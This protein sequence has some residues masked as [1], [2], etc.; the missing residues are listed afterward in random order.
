MLIFSLYTFLIILLI[1]GIGVDLMRF[2]RDRS[3]LQYTLDRAVLAA[4]DLDQPMQP[5][6]VVQDYFAKSGLGAY[7]AD[8]SV[9]QGTGYRVVSAT[10]SADMD[11]LFMHMNGV[12]TLTAPAAGTAEER[13]DGVEISMVLDV[14]GS[15]NSNNR[16][17]NLIVAARDFVDTMDENSAEGDLSIS[18]IPYATQVSVPD[19]LM[20]QFNVS[21]EHDYSN[22]INFQ[23]TD[24]DSPSM[25]GTAPYQRTMHFDPW[26]DYDGMDDNPKTLMGD[27]NSTLPV[28]EA[29][30]GREILA[31][32]NDTAIL[33]NYISNLT[34]RG[35]TSIDVG[36]KWGTALLDP[37]LRPAIGELIAAGDAPA[38]FANRPRNYDDS[39]TLKVI[40]LMT[41]G[42]NT[43]QY[44]IEDDHRE[45]PSDLWFNDE[46]DI[47]SVYYPPYDAYY[48][49]H[50]DKWADHPYGQDG[51]GCVGSNTS[52]WK[53]KDR[54]E[55]GSAENVEYPDLWAYVSLKANVKRRYYPFM[56]DNN[57]YSQ[58]YYGVRDYVNATVKNTRTKAICDIA[59]D[60]QIIVFTIAF[61]APSK[62][63][64][65]LKDCASSDA[66]Y[67]EVKANGSGIKIDDAFASIASSIRK[68][69]LTQ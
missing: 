10:A 34:A 45:G 68:L 57:A 14:S 35:N 19:T 13:I 5:T 11:T 25:S 69:R 26:N 55:D 61:E 9:N 60:Q 52:N 32:Q 27:N 41:D 63:R 3:R 30:P 56:N 48:W 58:W 20:E 47:W 39:D 36:M 15:M 40:V 6:S 46:E 59:K 28:C 67:F 21:D 38:E 33:K 17:P 16:L 51:M 43:Q 42:E 29:L 66:H 44:Y 12:D 54:T 53:C 2:E 31:M 8:V 24:F 37:S 64:T 62:G 4:A 50:E 1:G 49:P 65:V 18:I 22:C 23:S 7:L